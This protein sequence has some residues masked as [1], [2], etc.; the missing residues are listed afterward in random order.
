MSTYQTYSISFFC[1]KSKTNKKGLAP[2]EMAILLNGERAFINLPR[3]EKPKEFKVKL[4]QKKDNDIKAF[5]NA[6]YSFAQSKILEMVQSNLPL[7]AYSIK[8]YILK[9]NTVYTVEHLFNDFFD[10]LAKKDMTKKNYQKYVHMREEFFAVFDKHLPP[11]HLDSTVVTTYQNA[12]TQ[13]FQTSTISGYMS[14]LKSVVVYAQAKGH[15]IGNPFYNVK[16]DRR[17]KVVTTISEEEYRRLRD[18]AI[19]IDRLDKVRDYFVFACN[20]GLA[21]CDIV[22]LKPSDFTEVNGMTI[23]NKERVKTHVEFYSVVLNDGIEILRKY[24]YD[25]S[26]LFMSNQKINSY[27]KELADICGITSVDSLHC[28]LCRHFYLT[29]II[30]DGIPLEIVSRCAGHS[31]LSM[32]KHYA[33]QIKSNI[34]KGVVEAFKE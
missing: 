10:V 8:Q 11:S 28:H 7:T 16:I 6:Q 9:G 25:L 5:C 27:A 18:K 34:I 32:T 14:K 19:T 20:C 3:K 12:L 29:K 17:L 23:I 1:R 21:Y 26:P 13:K 15:I 31:R 4:N 30:N 24:H 22:Q 2:I 33:Q